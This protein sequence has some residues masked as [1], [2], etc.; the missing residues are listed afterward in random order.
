MFC[1]LAKVAGPPPYIRL[2]RIDYFNHLECKSEAGHEN[3][4]KW[5][6]ERVVRPTSTLVE[7]FDFLWDKSGTTNKPHYLSWH[8]AT[9]II[10]V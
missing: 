2:D 9:L 3:S 10:F 7:L 1:R 6:A 8:D 4:S 5:A